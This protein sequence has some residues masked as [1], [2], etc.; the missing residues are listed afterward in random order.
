MFPARILCKSWRSEQRAKN[1]KQTQF[2]RET[3]ITHDRNYIAIGAHV[4]AY[5]NRAVPKKT[6]RQFAN[7]KTKRLSFRACLKRNDS[8]SG[9]Y[10]ASWKMIP[11][12]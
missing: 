11:N 12:V 4:E 1:P 7:A 3:I 5:S 9:A 10:F 2:V 8:C 6:R